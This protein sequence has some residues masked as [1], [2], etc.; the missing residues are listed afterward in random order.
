MAMCKK[1][2]AR[3]PDKSMPRPHDLPKPGKRAIRESAN[4]EILCNPEVP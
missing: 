4:P 2:A 1:Q 3:T